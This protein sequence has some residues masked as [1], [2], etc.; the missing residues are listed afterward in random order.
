[1]RADIINYAAGVDYTLDRGLTLYAQYLWFRTTRPGATAAL[2][3]AVA[4]GM[5]LDAR[6]WEW[7]WQ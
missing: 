1:M 4:V 5:K 7:M 6:P 3:N 2:A